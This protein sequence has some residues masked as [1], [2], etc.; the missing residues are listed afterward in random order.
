MKKIS[1]LV[2]FIFNLFS[3]SQEQKTDSIIDGWQKSGKTSFLINQTAFSNWVSGGE[4]SIAGT[5][6]VDYNLNYAK[7]GWSWDTKMIGSFGVN[8]NT[9]V[10]IS[11]VYRRGPAANADILPGDILTH[12]NDQ[13]ITDG[14]AAMNQAAGFE[15]G[16]K[17]LVRLLRNGQPIERIVLV[18]QRPHSATN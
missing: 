9:G 17:I 14:R 18:G 16:A 12:M 1:I 2:F 3:F 4:N 6:S 13:K 7:N 8:K 5:L 11:G 10:L 15:P